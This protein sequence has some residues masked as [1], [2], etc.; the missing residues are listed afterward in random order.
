MNQDTI[1]TTFTYGTAAAVIIIGLIALVVLMF[2]GKIATDAAVPLLAA[3]I[4]APLQFLFNAAT[5]AAAVRSFQ[6]G[7]NTQPPSG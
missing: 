2:E 4:T 1:K 3:I 6:Q 7:L 5:G